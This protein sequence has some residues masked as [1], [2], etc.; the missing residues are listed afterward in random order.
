[1]LS[2]WAL[3]YAGTTFGKETRAAALPRTLRL[4]SAAGALLQPLIFYP[5]WIAM[6]LPL[7]RT[8]EQIDSL[9]SIFI[10]DLCFI[11][12]AFLIL[13]ILIFRSHKL[14]LILLPA[15]YI[16]G[17]T[18]IFSLAIGEIVKPLFNAALSPPALWPAVLLSMLS[19]WSWG[20]CISTDSPSARR[21]SPPIRTSLPMAPKLSNHESNAQNSGATKCLCP[22]LLT[23]RMRNIWSCVRG[24]PCN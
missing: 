12:P 19:S 20:R 23:A 10:L 16:L 21:I 5:L 8:G 17:F 6:L 24:Q 9:Y 7:M 4:A 18:L 22:H 3:I 15:L 1:M 11:M 2:F 13:S 14:G